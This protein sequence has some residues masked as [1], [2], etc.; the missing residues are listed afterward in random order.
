MA[1]RAKTKVSAGLYSF[2]NA[3]E[4]NA[5]LCLFQLPDVVY[6]SWLVALSPIFK[7][8]SGRSSPFQVSN[9]SCL[10]HHISLDQLFCP[11]PPLLR[12]PMIILDP[13]KLSMVISPFSRSID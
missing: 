4:E 3:L 12:D 2:P 5:F 10:F 7:T 13:H 6:V 11:P 1:L 9:L 8:S